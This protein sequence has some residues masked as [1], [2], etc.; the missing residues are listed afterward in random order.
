MSWLRRLFSTKSNVVVVIPREKKKPVSLNKY[1]IELMVKYY[2]SGAKPKELAE[3]FDVSM[4]TV[5]KYIRENK[6]AE[7]N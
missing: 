5:Y 1:S 4:T 2:K 7:D 6:N 3:L